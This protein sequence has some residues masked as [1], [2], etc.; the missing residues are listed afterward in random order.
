[1]KKLI[2]TLVVLSSLK[3]FAEPVNLTGFGI[4]ALIGNPTAFTFK[5]H[6]GNSRY[7]D[8]AVAYNAT[9]ADGMYVHGD[10]L[11]EK[12][13]AFQIQDELFDLYY[14]I[15]ARAYLA[16]SKKHN[17]EVHVG[18]RVPIGVSYYFKDPSVEVFGEFAA[19]VEITP[20]TEFQAQFGIGARYWF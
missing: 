17:D 9:P 13:E 7:F 16:D 11:F 5:G 20:E 19:I 18:P 6:M 8:V 12:P 1:M 10:Y 2:L 15:G 4:G 14:G 3:V